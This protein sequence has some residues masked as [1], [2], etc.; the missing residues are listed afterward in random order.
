MSK[1]SLD[2]DALK[3]DTRHGQ[4]LIPASDTVISKSLIKYGEW[5]EIELQHHAHFVCEGSV[6]M[7]IGACYGTHT[8][9]FA[10]MVGHTGGV[11]IAFEASEQNYC[12]L[13]RNA[14]TFNGDAKIETYLA[15]VGPDSDQRYIIHQEEWN[16]GATRVIEECGEIKSGTPTRTVDDYVDRGVS[17]IK[18]D[19]EGMES[20]VLKGASKTLTSLRPIIFFECNTV[21]CAS[22]SLRTLDEYHYEYF[23]DVT[24]AYNPDNIRGDSEDMFYGGVECGIY[25]IP[26]EKLDQFRLTIEEIGLAPIKNIEDIVLLM[27]QKPQYFGEALNDSNAAEILPVPDQVVYRT[28]TAGTSNPPSHMTELNQL[29]Q[30]EAT[31]AQEISRLNELLQSERNLSTATAHDIERL[32]KLLQLAKALE[33]RARKFPF[34]LYFKLKNKYRHILR[35]IRN[36]KP[37]DFATQIDGNRRLDPMKNHKESHPAGYKGESLSLLKTQSTPILKSKRE[38]PSAWVT[39]ELLSHLTTAPNGI[40]V[41]FSH[42]NYIVTPGGTQ[43]CVGIEQAAAQNAAFDYLHLYPIDHAPALAALSDGNHPALGVVFNGTALGVTSY[44]LMTEFVGKRHSDGLV[45]H[46][47]IHHAMGHEIEQVLRTVKATGS[48]R[49]IWWLH[50]F[51]TL[52]QSPHLLRNNVTFCTA[53]APNSMA[54]NICAYGNVREEH[55]ERMKAFFSEV[56]VDLIA[57]SEFVADTFRAKSTL[58][59]QSLIVQPHLEILWSKMNGGLSITPTRPIRIAFLGTPTQHKGWPNFRDL[60]NKFGWNP[61]YKFMYF[62]SHKVD[63]DIDATYVSTTGSNR[64]AMIDALRKA[65]VDIV[66]HISPTP[67]TFSITTHEALASGAMVI[68]NRGSGNAAIIIEKSGRGLII[69]N[70]IDLMTIF[71]TGK[72]SSLTD[73]GRAKRKKECAHIEFSEMA[74]THLKN[75]ENN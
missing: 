46:V 70:E 3:I 63:Q 29:K 6:V 32:N 40:I 7:D 38:T 34:S 71:D 33:K 65:A 14:E 55:L 52:C 17:F 15:V 73:L 16:R 69:D 64:Y 25:A 43:L 54:C 45:S 28:P 27:L 37:S 57:P 11:V 30:I 24:A 60:A 8:L 48:G 41:S 2:Q 26:S 23:G 47:V 75:L 66:I 56:N 20:S 5:A 67:E 58:T 74:L 21:T 35:E 53:P 42:D 44:G 49:C 50:D 68:T 12:F 9:A 51:F 39:P 22:E 4:L 13:S 19:V 36:A 31:M 59:Y 62:G 18:I 61:K 10:Q 72:I 1:I